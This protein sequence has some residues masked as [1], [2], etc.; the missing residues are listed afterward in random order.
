VAYLLNQDDDDENQVT[1]GAPQ[2]AGQGGLIQAGGAGGAAGPSQAGQ[3]KATKSGNFTNLNRYLTANE[4]QGGTMGQAVQGTVKTA[5]DAYDGAR[6]KLTTN[7]TNSVN[8]N[9]VRDDGTTGAVNN[10]FGGVPT[11]K[12]AAA[13]KPPTVGNV[14][15][16]PPKAITQAGLSA[17]TGATWKGPNAA[18]EVDG[19]DAAVTGA[20]KVSTY[21]KLAGDYDGSNTLLQE[22][23]GGNGSQYG[24]NLR[25]LDQFI[26]GGDSAG[27]AALDDIVTK[28]GGTKEAF[29]GSVGGLNQQIA[30]GRA[31]TT[32]T[33]TDAA[34]AVEAARGRGQGAIG[35]ATASAEQASQADKAIYDAISSGDLKTLGAFGIDAADVQFAKDRGIDL[36]T[37]ASSGAGSYTA[38]DKISDRDAGDYK[39]LMAALGEQGIELNKSGT[40][41]VSVD[42]GRAKALDQAAAIEAAAKKKFAATRPNDE[43]GELIGQLNSFKDSE[44]AAAAARLGIGSSLSDLDYFVSQGGD[45]RSL[46]KA[47]ETRGIADSMSN[48]DLANYQKLMALLGGKDGAGKKATGAA[49]SFDSGGFGSALQGYRDAEAAKVAAAEKA[50]IIAD[51][52]AEI[53]RQ[54]I[55]TKRR[56]ADRRGRRRKGTGLTTDPKTWEQAF[57]RR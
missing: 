30:D 50:K 11:K 40:K 32:K 56:V 28:Y 13:P 38:G 44:R 8:A 2:Q 48:A 20:Q 55:R 25:S 51:Q 41:G 21:G 54:K 57:R 34:A 4:G 26:L 53:E 17:L 12:V 5:A 24:S 16:G 33:A 27:K 3:E 52:Q 31:T 10:L 39:S 6:N 19:Y 45:I 46:L 29:D 18:S 37:L 47:G 22:T 1:P 23:Y 49:W 9:T 7:T 15:Q 14:T 42:G 43:M 36:R 35:A